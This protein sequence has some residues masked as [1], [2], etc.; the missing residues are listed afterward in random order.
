MLM[1]QEGSLP[2]H[3]STRYFLRRWWWQQLRR[4]SVL[5]RLKV[6]LDNL[7]PTHRRNCVPGRLFCCHYWWENVVL[8]QSITL[9]PTSTRRYCDPACLFVCLFVGWFVRCFLLSF[10]SS[11]SLTF[12]G[13]IISKTAGDT[14]SG[15]PY[16]GNSTWGIKWSRTWWHH[17]I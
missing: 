14:D 17:V 6:G 4:R 13:P 12:L 1:S 3:T 16:T 5:G 8:H 9:L 2:W 7:V 15:A 10:L 11:F